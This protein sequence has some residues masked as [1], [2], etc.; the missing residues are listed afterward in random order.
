M[1]ASTTAAV[2]EAT[3]ITLLWCRLLSILSTTNNAYVIVLISW[4]GYGTLIREPAIANGSC[5]CQYSWFGGGV[6]HWQ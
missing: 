4:Y 6:N 3:M 2:T 5:A 1:I